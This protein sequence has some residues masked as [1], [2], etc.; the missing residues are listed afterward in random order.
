[1]NVLRGDFDL[2]L[3]HLFVTSLLLFNLSSILYGALTGASFMLKGDLLGAAAFGIAVCVVLIFCA[4]GIAKYVMDQTYSYQVW[5]FSGFIS[6]LPIIFLVFVVDSPNDWGQ[7]FRF[8]IS[9]IA[10]YM[11][12]VFCIYE[13]CF[14][15]PSVSRQ[16]VKLGV[17]LAVAICS[18]LLGIV[19]YLAKSGLDLQGNH[20]FA[21]QYLLSLLCLALPLCVGIAGV[22]ARI[23]SMKS[24]K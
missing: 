10:F 7:I 19:I 2:R 16:S 11:L 3:N 14:K 1:M 12:P 18:F 20:N 9:T 22:R 6:F 5:I 17:L 15:E 24:H 13:A 21:M 8:C 4:Y 23:L